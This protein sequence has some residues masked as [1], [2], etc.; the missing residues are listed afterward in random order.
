[1]NLQCTEK[2]YTVTENITQLDDQI[3]C[4]FGCGKNDS[5]EKN[6]V[7]NVITIHTISKDTA[8]LMSKMENDWF[9]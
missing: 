2:S 9:R 5:S 8:V 3:A 6:C 7:I 4:T 1:M